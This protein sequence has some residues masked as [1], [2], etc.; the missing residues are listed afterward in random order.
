MPA[1]HGDRYMPV[2]GGVFATTEQ[3][4]DGAENADQRI[5]SVIDFLLQLQTD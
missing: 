3:L 1:A 2:W 4:I 5:Y